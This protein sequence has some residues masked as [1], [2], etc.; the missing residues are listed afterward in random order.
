MVT[1]NGLK[2]AMVSALI[3]TSY[4]TFTLVVFN[5]G[6]TDGFLVK[7]L[8]NWIIAYVLVVPSL[9]FVAPVIKRVLGV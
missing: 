5:L 1:K 9:L 4:V 8:F 3:V 7:W 6:F 2:L